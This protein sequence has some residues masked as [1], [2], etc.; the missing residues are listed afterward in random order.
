[1]R[2]AR[3]RT[4]SSTNRYN[5]PVINHPVRIPSLNCR[6]SKTYRLRN[7]TKTRG[8]TPIESAQGNEIKAAADDPMTTRYSISVGVRNRIWNRTSRTLV[9]SY[10]VGSDRKRV[11]PKCLPVFAHDAVRIAVK[12]HR[13][14][15]SKRVDGRVPAISG[16]RSRTTD[17][18]TRKSATVAVGRGSHETGSR[19]R[20]GR[21]RPAREG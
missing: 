9:R 4:I 1:M 19:H 12:L 10:R 15:A 5:C 3:P 8:K 21:L 6:N 11:Q 20:T 7:S 17:L 13:L 18:Y 16:A 14:S 2:S